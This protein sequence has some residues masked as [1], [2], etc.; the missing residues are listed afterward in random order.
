MSLPDP[1][2]LP[3]TRQYCKCAGIRIVGWGPNLLTVEAKSDA[4]AKDIASQL[5]SFGFHPLASDDNAHAGLL[6]LSKDPEAVIAQI[7][8]YDVTQPCWQDAAQPVIWGVCSLLLIP[9]LAGSDPREPYWLIAPLG[10]GA[11]VMFL[12]EAARIWGWRAEF[13]DGAFRVR[14]NF[15]WETILWERIASVHT[16]DAP[17]REDT[18]RLMLIPR[19]QLTIGTFYAPFARALR[20]KIC[21]ELDSRRAN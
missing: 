15:R 5:D 18:V 6:D 14:R 4:R 21:A 16:K 2:W 1:V 20:D 8:S 10:I 9:G 7:R 13:T 11:L 12:H 19:E 3:Q 17:G